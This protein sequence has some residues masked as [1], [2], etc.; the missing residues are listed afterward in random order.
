MKLV[1]CEPE[2]VFDDGCYKV[3]EEPQKDR[4]YVVGVDVAEGIGD[5]ASVIQILDIFDLTNIKLVA[6]YRNNKITPYNFTAKLLE[7][8]QHWGSPL[9]AIE[10]NN[11]GAQVVD[12]IHNTH[13]YSN[14][15]HFSPNAN[16]SANYADRLGVV[17]HTNTKYKGVMNMR[18]WAN[19]LN[20]L[21][22]KD[23]RTLNEMRSFVRYPN[24][25]WAAKKETGCFDDLVMALIWAL[26]VLEK[27]VTERYYDVVE[28][29]DNGKPL[30]IKSF[31]YGEKVFSNPLSIYNNEVGD[32]YVP[33]VMFG[34]GEDQQQSD[35]QELIS[36][37]WLVP[38]QQPPSE[39]D[40]ISWQS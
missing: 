6:S 25:S 15:I 16:K 19:E 8:L 32:G 17:A 35:M 12:Q 5:N 18:Y 27:G 7:I 33:P 23:I 11:C 30:K 2:F 28:L 26:I 31:D 40:D 36:M 1:C 14:L 13:G 3:W 4:E 39:E 24:G 34:L 29:D 22:I 20:V 37:G 9:V 10:R 21:E 38:G